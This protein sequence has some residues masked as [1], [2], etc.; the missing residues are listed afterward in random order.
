MTDTKDSK[1]KPVVLKEITDKD[2]EDILIQ[3]S[4]LVDWNPEDPR[5]FYDEND[6]ETL[7][8]H[9]DIKSHVNIDDPLAEPSPLKDIF[10]EAFEKGGTFENLG[11]KLLKASKESKTI[12]E[13][14]YRMPAINLILWAN[15]LVT[16][17]AMVDLV[18]EG[19]TPIH[20]YPYPFKTGKEF[21]ENVAISTHTIW[22]NRQEGRRVVD[23]SKFSF[24]LPSAG[25][26]AAINT[27]LNGTDL[28]PLEDLVSLTKSAANQI[29]AAQEAEANAFDKFLKTQDDLENIK[30]QLKEIMAKPQVQMDFEFKSDGEIPDGKLT[31]KK[32]S[33]VFGISSLDFD[34]PFFEWEGEHPLVP[35][36]DE[37]YLFREEYLE[38]ALFSLITNQ[39]AYLQGHT[40]SGKTTLLEQ[41][42]AHLNFPFVRIN[43]DSEITRMDLIGRDTLKGDVS[44]FVDGMLPRAMSMPCICCADEIDFVRP[45]VAYVMQSALEGNGL[46]I[47]EDGDRL[48]K[49]H[50][51]FRMFATGN[52]VGQ[53]DEEGMYQGARPQ[54]LALLD[55]FTV[56]IKVDYM[57]EEERMS[58]VKKHYPVLTSDQE[59]TLKEYVKEHMAAFTNG[60]VVKP[61]TPRGMLSIARSC[62]FFGDMSKAIKMTVL[63]ACTSSDRATLQGILD[64]VVSET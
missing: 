27:L 14:T 2:K 25:K 23:L 1:K 19:L 22:K 12:K 40:G 28:P 42:A 29:R 8:P 32:A 13:V 16:D 5:N 53:G 41:I 11:K 36:K 18:G 45:D 15:E 39:R 55:R 33:Y 46:R 17:K 26:R 61:M 54:S 9:V 21:I 6:P 24:S 59:H 43:F 7:N 3:V 10:V 49:P 51:M 64:R 50:P 34:V 38:R 48:V 35:S 20:R 56:W 4:E 58:L 60:E 44:E 62:T 30:K 63:D 37:N 47:T 57:N 31:Y 52:T